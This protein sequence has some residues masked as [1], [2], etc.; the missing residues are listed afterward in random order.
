VKD[1]ALWDLTLVDSH[2]HL[3]SPAYDRDRETVIAR[4]KAEGV[5]RIIDIGTDLEAS[6]RAVE[7]SEKYPG[8]IYAAVGVH[9]HDAVTVTEEVLVEL[10]K[11]AL[12]AGV[13]A[14][15]EIGLD[16]YRDLSPREEQ[17]RAFWEQLHLAREAGLPVIVHDRNA[18]ADVLAILREFS[19]H[20]EVRSPR[21]VLH[22]FSGDYSMACEAIEMGWYIS[23]AGP[24]TFPNAHRLREIVSQLPLDRLL[25]ETDCPYLAPQRY[26]GKRNEPAYVRWVVE[27][28]AQVKGLGFEEVARK[29]SENAC[30]L[31][32][33]S[34]PSGVGEKSS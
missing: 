22:C 34:G 30:R 25:V 17:R 14:I 33:F 18:H 3:N 6:R 16:Y 12:Q 11:M 13:V 1:T 9:P 21:G 8:I 27:R 32:G 29:T 10:R 23:V 4:A 26:R 31:F 15:G 2:A 24:V 28:I 5:T 19:A 20:E 7:L